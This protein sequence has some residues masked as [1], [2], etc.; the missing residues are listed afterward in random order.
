MSEVLE[1][2]PKQRGRWKPGESGNPGGRPAILKDV[3][4]M[5][6]EYTPLALKTLA[7][8]VGDGKAPHAA[9]VSAAQALMDRGWGKPVQPNELTGKDGGPIQTQ[10]VEDTRPPIELFLAE[11]EKERA[12]AKN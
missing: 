2:K 5:A 6:R 11:F 1:N 12:G 8:I 7:E 3:Q 4:E 10:V 9:R